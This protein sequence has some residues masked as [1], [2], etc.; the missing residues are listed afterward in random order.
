MHRGHTANALSGKICDDLVPKR[1]NFCP[2][3]GL[4]QWFTGLCTTQVAL[5]LTDPGSAKACVHR[6]KPG[7]G[8]CLRP[9][10]CS[11]SAQDLAALSVA[12]IP[13][14]HLILLAHQVASMILKYAR[15]LTCVSIAFL[16]SIASADE[17]AKWTFD[18]EPAGWTANDQA[19]LSIQDG[20]LKLRAKGG[21]PYFSTQVNGRA[22]EHRLTI[23]AKF[24][25]NADIQL[26][27]TTEADP[28]TSEEKS[29]KAELR[30][31]D[32]EFRNVRLHF[33]TESPVT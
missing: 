3:L 24:K 21:D 31:S 17:I 12:T 1:A 26:F 13:R 8:A 30:G 5:E 16:S 7:G 22:G 27:W 10:L 6:D 19:E 2:P 4:P 14:I 33:V 15:H 23:S 9:A 20:A 11:G 29:V 18:A 28:N 32:K 25:G